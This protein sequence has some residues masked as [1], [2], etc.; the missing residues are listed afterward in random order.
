MNIRTFIF[1]SIV[2]FNSMGLHQYSIR[3]RF[4]TSEGVPMR[5]EPISQLDVFPRRGAS[6]ED[7]KL[8]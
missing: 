2:P 4:F 3:P 7:I 8:R 5:F 1:P 6:R